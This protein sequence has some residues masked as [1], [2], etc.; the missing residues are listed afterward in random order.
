M[1][2]VFMEN[3]EKIIGGSVGKARYLRKVMTPTERKLWLKLR[4]RRFHGL[5]FR[6]Q[7]P[8]GHY[9]ADFFCAEKRLIVEIDG[10]VH[11][12]KIEKDSLRGIYF[13]EKGITV[14]RFTN[15]QVR[16]NLEWVLEEM[17]RACGLP[18]FS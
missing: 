12:F 16:S 5:K 3:H 8:I 1:I 15:V 11:A 17:A 9:C 7:V 6:R 2:I 4:D 14:I 18:L 13:M 10:G